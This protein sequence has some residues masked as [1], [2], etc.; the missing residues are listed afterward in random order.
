VAKLKTSILHPNPLRDVPRLFSALFAQESWLG[1]SA[2]PA[3]KSVC[4]TP[5]RRQSLGKTAAF[6]KLCGIELKHALPDQ[7]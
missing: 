6:S 4:A 2:E 1:K 7:S 3:D 5:G